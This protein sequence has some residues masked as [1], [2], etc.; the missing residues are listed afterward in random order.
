MKNSAERDYRAMLTKRCWDL[1]T[2]NVT[3]WYMSRSYEEER[4]SQSRTLVPCS[5]IEDST[6]VTGKHEAISN[7]V[8]RAIYQRLDNC[9]MARVS[10]PRCVEDLRES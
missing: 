9:V 3:I 4:K 10:W 1:A 6:K 5:L 7:I 8:T 2:A